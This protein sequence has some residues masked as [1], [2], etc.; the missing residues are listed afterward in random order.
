MTSV[1]TRGE[2]YSKLIEYLRKGQEEAAVLAH[3]HR[4][5][6]RTGRAM[7]MG[8]LAVSEGLKLMQK[9]VTDLARRGLQ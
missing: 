1:P 7:A 6:S 8:W 4:D 9:Q 5:D 2:S 3:L